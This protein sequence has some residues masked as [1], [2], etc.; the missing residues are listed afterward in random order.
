V[1]GA[2]LLTPLPSRA[3][4]VQA[5]AASLL[6]GGRHFRV[7]E[8]ERRKWVV[9]P[10]PDAFTRE[11]AAGLA[12]AARRRGMASAIALTT[13]PA[14][15]QEQFLVPMTPEGILAFDMNCLLRFFLMIPGDGSFAVL[16][17][18]NYY[19]LLAGERALVAEALRTS[20]EEAFGEFMSGYVEGESW[21]PQTAGML[22]EIERYRQLL[23]TPAP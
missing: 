8:M 22:R 9:A 21:P 17:E 10:L 3:D 13:E 4:D 18:A 23:A 5:M 11:Q 1:S 2:G 7:A 14:V 6:D 15:Q 20:P 16:H 19:W 12:E